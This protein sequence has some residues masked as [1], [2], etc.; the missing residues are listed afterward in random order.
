MPQELHNPPRRSVSKLRV[1]NPL[2]ELDIILNRTPLNLISRDSELRAACGTDLGRLAKIHLA[3]ELLLRGRGSIQGRCTRAVEDIQPDLVGDMTIEA[4]GVP[5]AGIPIAA[6]VD[7]A[8]LLDEIGPET[9]HGYDVIVEWRIDVP[10][11]EEACAMSVEKGDGR[12]EIVVGVDYVREVGHGF[13]AFVE[14]SCKN[15][16]I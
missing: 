15:I 13:M 2:P 1:D 16:R 4:M 3:G 11:H 12:G 8:V 10:C 6:K 9:A 5:A 7:I 14:W